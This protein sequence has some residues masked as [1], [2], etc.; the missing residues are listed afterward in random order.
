MKRI[1]PGNDSGI[2]YRRKVPGG[3]KGVPSRPHS[4]SR[5][6]IYGSSVNYPD[7]KVSYSGVSK[8]I[9][10]PQLAYIRILAR[11]GYPQEKAM[12]AQVVGRGLF[13]TVIRLPLTNETNSVLW[14]LYTH[15]TNRR[16]RKHFPIPDVGSV[17]AIVLKFQTYGDEFDNTE[18]FLHQ[19]TREAS[20]HQHL[21]S[22]CKPSPTNNGKTQW[23]GSDI[24][25]NF[26]FSGMVPKYGTYVTCMGVAEG[27]PLRKFRA[28]HMGV[29]P[30]DAFQAVVQAVK[31][32]FLLGVIHGDMHENNVFITKRPPYKVTI[33]DFG[34]AIRIPASKKAFVVRKLKENNLNGLWYDPDMGLQRNSNRT[35][36]SRGFTV[37]HADGKVLRFLQSVTD[38]RS[39]GKRKRKSPN[40]PITGKKK[41]V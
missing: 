3:G 39:T 24:V 6:H 20:I 25:P 30:T 10:Y 17:D 27:E 40:R 12:T 9:N 1:S 4:Y 14:R 41:R 26:Y 5:T 37:Y 8:N 38:Q 34:Y 22:A 15:V 11:F 19:M 28:A 13:G 29:I 36:H 32:M 16:Q 33:I 7:S 2:P 21:S 23:C 31:I 35:M 18:D